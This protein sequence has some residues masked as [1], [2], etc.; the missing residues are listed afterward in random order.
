M[1]NIDSGALQ[2]A[3]DKLAEVAPEHDLEA[4]LQGVADAVVGLF[5]VTGTGLMFIDDSDALRYVV[6][7]DEAGR[8]LEVAQEE[9]GVGP[10]VDCL[11]LDTPIATGDIAAD[12]RWPGLADRVVP[13]GVRAVL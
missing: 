7:S 4:S 2:T 5:S 13:A 9:R 10:G 11:V 1:P 6:S 3:L 12:A 8:V